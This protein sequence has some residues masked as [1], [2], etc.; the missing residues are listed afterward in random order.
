M[1]KVCFPLSLNKFLQLAD[2]FS[3]YEG[4]SLLY[5]GGDYSTSNQSFLFLFPIEAFS[6]QVEKGLVS[7]SIE[8]SR[9]IGNKNPW[10]LLKQ[11]LGDMNDSSA[12]AK[13][14]GFFSYEM[15][16]FSDVRFPFEKS[17]YPLAFFQRSALTFCFDH[18]KEQCFLYFES[19]SREKIE[20]KKWFDLLTK[21]E[22]RTPWLRNLELR[23]KSQSSQS[24]CENPGD[25]KEK[26]V[27]KIEKIIDQIKKG[28]VYQVCLSH[29]ILFKSD[30]PPFD[31][32][33]HLSKKNPS[34]RSEECRVGKV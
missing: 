2:T 24:F 15:G 30:I 31:L 7:V 13:W 26:Y 5:S 20:E 22:S 23:Q 29:E 27:K 16:F 4:T 25:S 34:P 12:I 18:K 21:E 1:N 19:S 17:L 3:D 14:V 33:L 11:D 6:Y 28:D 9:I 32:F 10:D 8:K